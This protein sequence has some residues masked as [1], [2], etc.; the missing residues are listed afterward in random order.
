MKKLIFPAILLFASLTVTAQDM[1]RYK[2]PKETKDSNVL[3]ITKNYGTAIIYETPAEVQEAFEKK[4]T[5]NMWTA[6]QKAE[7]TKKV[8]A[9]GWLIL[10]IGRA[11]IGAADTRYFTVVIQD[12]EGNEVLRKQLESSVARP[13]FSGSVTTWK[14]SEVLWMYDPLKTGYKVFVIDAINKTRYEYLI[15]N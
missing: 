14:N 3:D 9:G 1:P 8:P 10:D 13:L 5:L 11:T 12:T 2:K 4:A 6:E 7:E 15:Q